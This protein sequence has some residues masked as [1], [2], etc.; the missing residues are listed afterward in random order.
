M[1]LD[2]TLP[3]PYP[4]GSEEK[5]LC[6]MAR[7]ERRLP[8]FLPGDAVGARKVCDGHATS[9]TSRQYGRVSLVNR[10]ILWSQEPQ[11]CRTGQQF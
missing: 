3:C 2:P 9:F 7:R 10:V 4:P 6:L 11:F 1:P 5:I 8:L